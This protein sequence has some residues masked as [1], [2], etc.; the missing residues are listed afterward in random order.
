MGKLE[1]TVGKLNFRFPG[2]VASGIM[3]ETGD[4]MVRMFKSG[5]GAVVTKSIGS[6][7]RPGHANP[8]F[9]EVGC[10]YVNA[11]GLPN[12]GIDLFEAEVGMASAEGPVVGSVFGGDEKEFAYLASK[13]EEYGAVA[14]ELN[15]SCPH[16]AGYGA[17]IGSVPEMITS[18]VSEVK[19][20]VDI[21]VWAKLTPNTDS[22]PALGRAAERG[23]A[24]ALVAIN[25]L[26]AMVICPE[27]R[28]P[29]LSNKFGG[30]SGPGVKPVG[31]RAVYDLYNA[32]DIPIIGVGGI[33]DWRDAVEYVMAGASA[34]QIG[35]AVGTVGTE[36]FDKVN[37]GVSAF[38][39]EQGFGSV[40]DM[41]GV[42]HD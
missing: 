27:L 40:K 9:T 35:S 21:P 32:V 19:S 28:K 7:P 33:T 15:L 23:G 12:P 16:A 36:I 30:L 25:T 4:S 18:V 31:V 34:F 6:E 14:V 11:M 29:V 5:A 10:G 22:V 2:I 3:D 1:V 24:D 8:T 41:V 38:M 37:K 20:S 39:D 13:M 26:K 42:A 17:E